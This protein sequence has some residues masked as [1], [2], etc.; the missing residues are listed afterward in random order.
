MTTA[1]VVAYRTERGFI[2][3]SLTGHSVVHSR[4]CDLESFK[5]S[6]L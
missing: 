2:V 3:S 6:F 4:D 5:L 1:E